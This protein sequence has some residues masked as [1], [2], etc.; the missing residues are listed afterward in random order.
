MSDLNPKRVEA[1]KSLLWYIGIEL[2]GAITVKQRQSKLKCL[3]VFS[4]VAIHV[5]SI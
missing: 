4:P 1:I 2:F 5:L 3:G